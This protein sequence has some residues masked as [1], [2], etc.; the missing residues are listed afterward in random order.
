MQDQLPATTTAE[1]PWP[2]GLAVAKATALA[3]SH[4]IEHLLRAGRRAGGGQAGVRPAAAC[5]VGQEGHVD[6]ARRVCES[7]A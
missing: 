4:A 7:V 3:L 6:L 2:Q 5:F 1:T